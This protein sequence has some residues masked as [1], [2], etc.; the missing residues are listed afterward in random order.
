MNIRQLE[1]VVDLDEPLVLTEPTTLRGP[2]VLRGSCRDGLVYA[3]AEVVLEGLHLERV[4]RPDG[5]ASWGSCV[6]VE[7]AG[8]AT[9][10]DC[11]VTGAAH[12][13]L[14]E[15]Q[16]ALRPGEAWVHAGIDVRGKGHA[17]VEDCAVEDCATA[18]LS[19]SVF[20]A[21][22]APNLVVRGGAVRRC[23][24]G[25]AVL[26]EARAEVT[27]LSVEAVSE[28][29][30]YVYGGR[31]IVTDLVVRA[32][33]GDAI[34]A[35]DGSVRVKGG[36]FEGVG[37]SAIVAAKAAKVVVTGARF[38]DPQRSGVIT[39]DQASVTLTD[40]HIGAC[41]IHGLAAS[42]ASA[43]TVTTS[44]LTSVRDAALL[45]RDAATLHLDRCTLPASATWAVW[46]D[47]AAKVS[48]R[49]TPLP[50]G[51]ADALG[52]A[53]VTG[54]VTAPWDSATWTQQLGERA[55]DAP[56]RQRVAAA[57]DTAEGVPR[58]ELR[59]WAE[60]GTWTPSTTL[61]RVSTTQLGANV[62][63]LAPWEGGC[64]VALADDTVARLGPDGA[65][66]WRMRG[67]RRPFAL[68]PMPAGVLVVGAAGLRALAA[69]DGAQVGAL[70]VV[71]SAIALGDPISVVTWDD[72]GHPT[73]RSANLL[74][75]T[76][77]DS[78]P[79]PAEV[80]GH[81]GELPDLPYAWVT[82]QARW[83]GGEAKRSGTT[84]VSGRSYHQAAAI[85][86]LDDLLFVGDDKLRAYRGDDLVA[87]DPLGP[88][89]ALAADGLHVWAATRD[90]EV[91]QVEVRVGAP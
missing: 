2:A 59:Q 90:G 1:G 24:R 7:G 65:V 67:P 20:P 86:G 21:D 75:W 33:G 51:T 61:H 49:E 47:V 25:I 64:F 37:G 41:G 29:A 5:A 77:G 70:P 19:A 27:G 23:V 32:C 66:V 91:A 52:A 62:T 87:V 58:A 26:A 45:A 42:G 55:Y 74:R 10:R 14:V 72:T 68:V 71:P 40:V 17:V 31:L 76:P 53:E 38:P 48:L 35:Q 3:H 46:A 39:L 22:A 89:T 15:P 57:I 12:G 36:T 82:A 60:L 34:S 54:L 44:T 88:I 56:T 73:D 30:V 16:T 79:P 80:V 28:S 84:W 11:R 4:P 69:S 85:T 78:A 8:V 9:L 50:A 83:P 63:A 13:Y 81:A 43:L 6:V 18:G